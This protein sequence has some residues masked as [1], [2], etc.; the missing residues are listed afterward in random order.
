MKADTYNLV[1]VF[2]ANARYLIPLFQRPYV[3]NL[4]D[5]WTPLWDDVRRVADELVDGTS[6]HPHFLGAIVLASVDPEFGQVPTWEVIDGQQRLT[7]L[8]VLFAAARGASESAAA[9]QPARLLSLFIANNEVLVPADH[10]EARWKVWPT[11][12][13]Q[14]QFESA[15]TT[16][17]GK[18]PLV[19]A[20]RWFEQE[21]KEWISNGEDPSARAN[22]LVT[23]LRERLRLVVID[24]ER[25]D[26]PQV[27][28][29][30]LNGRGTPLE[31]AD[32]V[33]NLLFRTAARRF[34]YLDVLY[35][36]WAPF[37]QED[38]RKRVSVGRQFRSRLDVFLTH[39][40]SMRTLREVTAS[41]LYA[42]FAGWLASQQPE[43]PAVF[44]ELRR[45]AVIYDSFDHFDPVSIEGRFF[46]R[47]RAHQTLTVVPLLLHVWGRGDAV[48]AEQR[49]RI[50]SAV[51][52]FLMR[53]SVCGLTTKDYNNLFRDVLASVANERDDRLDLAVVDALAGGTAESRF[54]PTDEQFRRSLE[55]ERLF[56]TMVRARL[57]TLLEAIEHELRT[58]RSEKLVGGTLTVEHILPRAWQAEDWPLLDGVES[59]TRDDILHSLG[60]LTLVTGRLNSTLSNRSWS[61]K[62]DWLGKHSLLRLTSGSVMNAPPD[63]A[64]SQVGAWADEWNEARIATRA[65]HLADIALRLWPDP[66][67]LGGARSAGALPE[68]GRAPE[69]VDDDPEAANEDEVGSGRAPLYARFWTDYLARLAERHPDWTRWATGPAQNWLPMATG[70]TGVFITSSFA[71]RGR[72][73]HELYIDRTTQAECK[74]LFDHLLAQRERFEEAY[75]RPLDWERLDDGKASRIA[76]YAS[77]R[78]AT[79]NH[80]DEYMAFFE[81]AGERMRAALQAVDVDA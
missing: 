9:E 55:T 3:W 40:L 51:D 2:D 32:L 71:R 36:V 29:E 16:A 20:R 75:G 24:L 33:K 14:S 45:F 78:V 22:A 50:L 81:E 65:R 79:T 8:Q 10:P 17:D 13:D 28:F 67:A 35:A 15:M 52:S 18:G 72:L 7:T 66:T 23:T 42:G 80:H 63:A 61:H 68:A 70:I 12:A 62:K 19:D 76:E 53:R 47:L 77:G 6:V 11:K 73:R 34:E 58:V 25:D 48:S 37:D 49:E 59:A 1:T 39:W 43:P 5:N 26:D 64:A 27:I 31:A 4:D 30:T 74:R 21:I 41:T 44:A 56:R 46:D 57:R 60:N 38:W 54:W 69:V